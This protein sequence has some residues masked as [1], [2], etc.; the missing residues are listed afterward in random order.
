MPTWPPLS[1]SLRF[2]L[3]LLIFSS[4]AHSQSQ[5]GSRIAQPIDERIRVTLT[6]N[7]H[8]LAQARCDLGAVPDSFPAE[9]M[10]LLLQRTGERE[11]ALRQFLHDAHRPG[12]P[13]Y[14]KWLTPEQFAELY[15]PDDADVAAVTGWLQ[16]HGFS[17]AR[18]TKGKTAIEFSGTAGQLRETFHTEIHIYAVKGEQHYANNL[19]PQVPAALAPV[20][21]GITPMND[22]QPTSYLRDLGKAVYDRETHKFVPQWTFPS[23]Q[24][25]LE[26]SPGDFALQYDLN[27][28]YAAGITGTGVTIGLIG[29]SNVDPTVVATYRSFFGL[30]PNPLNV[31]VDGLDPGENGA[32][33]ESYLDVEE[34]G[35]VAPG[36]TITLYTSAGTSLQSGLYLAAQRAVD[37][38]VAAVLS[39]SYGTCEQYLGSAGNQFWNALWEQAAAQG[40]TSFVSAGDGGPAGCDNFN[41]FQP[42]QFGVATNGF[43]STP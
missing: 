26:L 43:S 35:A 3:L 22:F 38:D 34:A 10:F 14:H 19:D 20:I 42:A 25:A 17:V 29:A 24:D 39:T 41:N 16:K 32:F 4:L 2:L 5:P 9:R 21:A 31:V 30:P 1:Y 23:G 33:V 36:A 18:V 8:P 12:S 6:G 15:G 40:Q 7:V 11:A 13:S 27:P 37:D 28:L